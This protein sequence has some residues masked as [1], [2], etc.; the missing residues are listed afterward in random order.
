MLQKLP[1]KIYVLGPLNLISLPVHNYSMNLLFS[2]YFWTE[3][4]Y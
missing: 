4:E 3:N 1:N 2:I